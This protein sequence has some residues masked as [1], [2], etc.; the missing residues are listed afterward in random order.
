MPGHKTACFVYMADSVIRAC[1]NYI[2]RFLELESDQV[3]L[4]VK[5]RVDQKQMEIYLLVMS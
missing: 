2:N 1:G 3:D 4:K 5:L